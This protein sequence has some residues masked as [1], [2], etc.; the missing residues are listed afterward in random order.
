VIQQSGLFPRL[1]VA[2]NVASV[3][4][5]L[6]WDHVRVRAW[7][8]EILA[9]VGLD[10]AEYP[11]RYPNELSGGQAQRVGVARALAG[12]P[13]VLLMDEPF[14]AASER[15]V[16]RQPPGLIVGASRATALGHEHLFEYPLDLLVFLA[17]SSVC[18]AD[19]DDL[20]RR[21]SPAYGSDPMRR[22]SIKE[23]P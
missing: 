13:P 23:T 4:R 19:R 17:I 6:G 20:A 14:G 12:D 3:P 9:L 18:P 7:V 11:G 15:S 2:D 8:D 22:Q 5:L 21:I 1:K 16:A 10:P